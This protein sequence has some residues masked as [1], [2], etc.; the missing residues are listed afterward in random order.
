[1]GLPLRENYLKMLELFFTSK[2]GPTVAASLERFVRRG[3]VFIDRL[4]YTYKPFSA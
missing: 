3:Y 1:M 2:S 4:F